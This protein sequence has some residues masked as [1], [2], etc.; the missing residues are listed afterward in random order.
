MNYLAHLLY[1]G[2]YND[3]YQNIG[4]GG[5]EC[6]DSIENGLRFQLNAISTVEMI[7]LIGIL[8]AWLYNKYSL[9]VPVNQEQS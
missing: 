7:F 3:S 6:Y 8:K 9:P 1:G 5:P 4:D 2:I